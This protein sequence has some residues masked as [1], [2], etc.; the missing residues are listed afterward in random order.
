MCPACRP[1]TYDEASWSHEEHNKVWFVYQGV[2]NGYIAFNRA[3][4]YF[5]LQERVKS[6]S[7][8]IV[9]ATVRLPGEPEIACAGQE[10]FN[11]SHAGLQKSKYSRREL[12]QIDR[13]ISF[14]ECKDLNNAY[15]SSTTAIASYC[16]SPCGHD[17]VHHSM[18][19]EK[20]IACRGRPCRENGL[21]GLAS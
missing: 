9:K 8:I 17:C 12:D 11:V 13:L 6:S 4:F 15:P 10:C 20:N 7:I 19:E 2:P 3:D 1:C 21:K 16:P 14:Q 18:D 5:Y